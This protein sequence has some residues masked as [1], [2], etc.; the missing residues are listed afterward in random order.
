MYTEAEKYKLDSYLKQIEELIEEENATRQKITLIESRMREV[1]NRSGVNGQGLSV[2][3]L[4]FLA[5]QSEK[6]VVLKP[7]N[8]FERRSNGTCLTVDEISLKEH[9]LAVVINDCN[10]K[11]L[12][13]FKIKTNK[14]YNKEIKTVSVEEQSLQHLSFE[15][16][17]SLTRQS[18]AVVLDNYQQEHYRYKSEILF[19]IKEAEKTKDRIKSLE[20]CFVPESKGFFEKDLK[21]FEA[22]KKEEEKRE[23]KCLFKNY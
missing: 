10:I 13:G 9:L 19:A 16:L 11:S 6:F 2:E 5:N 18:N 7:C 17:K 15:Q 20:V 1:R 21:G 23:L 8:L 12:L 14:N 22:F 4:E 3:E